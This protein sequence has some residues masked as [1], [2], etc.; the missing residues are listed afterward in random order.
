MTFLSSPSNPRITRLQSLHTTRGRK[1][2]GLF[3]MEGPHLLAALLDAQ[4]LPQEVYYHPALLERT[5]EGR[6]L[7]QRILRLLPQQRLFEVS[8]RVIEAIGE[9]QTSQGV[10]CVLAMADFAPEPVRARR[11]GGKRPALLILD[12]LADPGNMG[13]ILRTA[14]AADVETVLLTPECVDYFNPKVVR[15]AA[16]AHLL[17]PVQHNMSWDAITEA[18]QQHCGGRV[19]LAE[20]GSAQMYYDLDLAQPFALVIGNE[21]HGPSAEARQ[22]ATESI[23]IPLASGVESLNAAM[24]T[25][26]ILYEA[27]R[28]RR[29]GRAF[30]I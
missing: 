17:L 28:Q 10:V 30:P 3:L 27:V 5:P 20:A 4:L 25:G 22:R 12:N 15:A 9:T 24:A 7:L 16:G 14:L 13:T 1:K 2:T 29:Q 6:D 23:S 26:I 19:L 11:A 18:V 8:E 21:A